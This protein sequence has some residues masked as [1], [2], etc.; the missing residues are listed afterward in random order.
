MQYTYYVVDQNYLRSQRLEQLLATEPDIRLVLPDLGMFEMAAPDERELTVRL[1]LAII[2]KHP[3]RVFVARSE[4][5]CLKYELENAKSV[6]GHMLFREATKSLRRI[7]QAVASGTSNQDLD[8]LINDP[9]G[10]MPSLKKDY[11]DHISNKQRSLELVEA[12]KLI[13][14][15]DF[16]RDIRARCNDPAFPAQL[17]RLMQRLQ[18]GFSYST[19]GVG[20]GGCKNVSSRQSHGWHAAGSRSGADG[21][22]A[23]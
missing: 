18:P 6:S 16:A 15:A 11:L 3:N 9:E 2:A 4:S 13:M 5:E 19:P 8:R 17:K 22:I 7:L 1:S 21:Y 12:T 10:H 23:L 14:T 20:V